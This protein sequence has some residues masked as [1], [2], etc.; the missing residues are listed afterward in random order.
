MK[1]IFALGVII[2]FVVMSIIP[3]T[4]QDIEKTALPTSSG[5]WLYVGG[6]GPGNYTKIQDA[7][8]DSFDGDTVFVCH[9]IYYEN[10]VINVSIQ[11]IGENKNTTVVDGKYIDNVISVNKSNTWIEGFSIIRSGTTESIWNDSGINLFSS[12]NIIANCNFYDNYYGVMIHWSTTNNT[13]KNNYFHENYHGMCIL[14]GANG[15]RF[16]NNRVTSNVDE[17]LEVSGWYNIISGN[18]FS[19][20]KNYSGVTLIGSN[21]TV[22][23]NQIANNLYGIAC[24]TADS[25]QIVRN[26]FIDNKKHAD[27]YYWGLHFNVFANRWSNNYW[28][29][30]LLPGLFPKI[31]VGHGS[32]LPFDFTYPYIEVDK[33][34][35]KKPYDIP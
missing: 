8:N 10:V 15:N 2:L 11:L 25:N 5:H 27:I 28:S 24:E 4:A 3:T 6:S 23:D 22:Q 19:N 21:N 17:G 35:A 32:L 33:H 34:P 29:G 20:H 30:S 26:N 31:I 12:N 1:K 7:I 13:V 16:I 18:V 14:W 9:G